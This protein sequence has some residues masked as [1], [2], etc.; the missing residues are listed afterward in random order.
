MTFGRFI[1]DRWHDQI[2]LIK[3]AWGGTNLAEEWNPEATSGKQLYKEL[4]GRMHSAEELLE[5]Q[6]LEAEYVGMLWMQG[7]ADTL[8]VEFAQAFRNNQERFIAH[9][10]EDLGKAHLP[11]I[12]G[13]IVNR[14]N[15]N[16]IYAETVRQAQAEVAAADANTTLVLTDDLPD[17]GDGTR[18]NAEALIELGER[19]AR[20]YLELSGE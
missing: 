17:S 15:P 16:M 1:A 2:G 18:F 4:M 7:E 13:Q 3:V 8:T 10:R 6:E 19:F 9:V 20:A 11:F 5:K 14:T 12:M